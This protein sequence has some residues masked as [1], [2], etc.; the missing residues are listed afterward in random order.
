MDSSLEILILAGGHSSRMGSPKHLL[1]RAD[2]PLYLHLIQTLHAALPKINTYH[3]SLA[4][5]SAT[6]EIL[7]AGKCQISGI[8]SSAPTTIAINTIVDSVD[9]DIGP[10]AGLLAA[11]SRDPAATWLILACDFPFVE[12]A[13]VEQLIKD[14][15]EP[16]TCFRNEAGFIEPL[17]GIWSPQALRNLGENVKA[18]H[19]GPSYTL[20]RLDSKFL[21]PSHQEW[22]LNVNTKQEWEEAQD[23]LKTTQLSDAR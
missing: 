4:D 5:R 20:K 19:S 14:Y 11:H 8:H 10:A 3:I 9:E 16:A 15:E 12:A 17:L 2:Q 22:L 13:T 6:D 23:R 7:R 21:V 18:G 1:L